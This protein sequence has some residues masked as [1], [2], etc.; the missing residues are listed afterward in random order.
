MARTVIWTC[1]K[2][3]MTIEKNSM[4]SMPSSSG[5]PAG[6]VHKWTKTYI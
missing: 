4:Q 1:K 3:G 5:C 6:G 2:C